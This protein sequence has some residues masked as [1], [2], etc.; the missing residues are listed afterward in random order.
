MFRAP[1]ILELFTI[2][3][4]RTSLSNKKWQK[5][6]EGHWDQ[7]SMVGMLG[8]GANLLFVYIVH[9]LRSLWS[10]RINDFLEDCRRRR[11]S[12]EN[13]W[14][15]YNLLTLC[16]LSGVLWRKYGLI[17]H[18]MSIKSVSILSIVE[19]DWPFFLKTP[20]KLHNLS[21]L[22]SKNNFLVYMWTFMLVHFEV[23][24]QRFCQIRRIKEIGLI[25]F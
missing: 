25:I 3:L 7:Y 9:I 2:M 1:M 16:N 20:D 17:F 19:L 21:I 13:V 4:I 10:E 12:Q 24:H 5:L 8:F 11:I 22:W 15:L 23:H 18:T 14:C 6:D